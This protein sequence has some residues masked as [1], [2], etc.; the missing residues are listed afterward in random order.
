MKEYISRKENKVNVVKVRLTVEKNKALHRLKG[1]ELGIAVEFL[2]KH[3][4]IIQSNGNLAGNPNYECYVES[5]HGKKEKQIEISLLNWSIV[6]RA[7]IFATGDI[8]EDRLKCD[9]V[10]DTG[11]K[12][13]LVNQSP[14]TKDNALLLSSILNID[15]RVNIEHEDK[16][17]YSLEEMSIEKNL[18]IIW[19]K[20]S[21]G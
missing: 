13:S 17:F 21:K 12:I 14:S 16:L 2:D 1:R 5:S 3:I 15:N 20:E 6:R 7:F 10:T 9:I 8:M 19:S 11:D 4:L 18:R